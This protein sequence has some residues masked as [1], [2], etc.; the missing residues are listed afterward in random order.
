MRNIEQL[1]QRQMVRA[2]MM[3][4]M[5][6][7]AQEECGGVA[8]ATEKPGGCHPV[9]CISRDLGSGARVIAKGL[10]DKLGYLLF[11]TASLDA[12]ARDMEVQRHLIDALDES[13]QNQLELMIRTFMAGRELE[14]R[15]YIRSLSHVVHS[16]AM[17]GGVVMLGRGGTYILNEHSALNVY[18]TCP[19]ELRIERVMGYESLSRADAEKRVQASDLSR[20]KFI[21]QA[22]KV[23][24]A[25]HSAFDLVINTARIAPEEA[26]GL[27]LEALVARGYDLTRMKVNVEV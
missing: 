18:I 20:R 3:A 24:L 5:A 22:F 13:A 15:D 17:Q 8:V 9:I 26:A 25:D 23:D 11:G 6:R 7:H 10:C 19:L 14:H 27:V 2:R 12:I 4:E 16:M 1:V 21:K